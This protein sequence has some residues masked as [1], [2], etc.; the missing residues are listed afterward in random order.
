MNTRFDT[1]QVLNWQPA[2]LA[3]ACGRVR[4][5]MQQL[6]PELAQLEITSRSSHYSTHEP[7]VPVEDWVRSSQ[8]QLDTPVLVQL[9]WT[10][11]HNRN[12]PVKIVYD[13][14]KWVPAYREWDCL[15]QGK[16]VRVA[17]IH[18]PEPG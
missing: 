11:P 16:V 3:G 15:R 9:E 1:F 5:L 7:F 14:A 13:V 8:C 12:A 2:E 18:F 6:L 17:R 4:E 10:D